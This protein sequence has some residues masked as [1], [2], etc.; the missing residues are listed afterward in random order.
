[1]KKIKLQLVFFIIASF[2]SFSVW[3]NLPYYPIEF[4]RDEAGHAENVP[5]QFTKMTEWWYYN[6]TLT[7]KTG[8]KFGYYISFNSMYHPHP[9]KMAGLFQ[10]QITD[11]DKKKVYAKQLFFLDEKTFSIST[12]DLNISFGKKLSLYKKNASYI[13]EGSVL[14]ED[15]VP[16]DFSLDLTQKPTTDVLLV[17]GK[18]LMPMWNNTN[19]YYYSYT[20]LKTKGYLKIGKEVFE[21]DPC[22]SLSW[23]DHQWGDFII[24][25]GKNQWMWTSIQLKN[26]LDIN[27]GIILDDNLKPVNGSASLVVPS[28]LTPR[29]FITDLSKLAYTAEKVQPGQ[30][31]PLV[32]HLSIPFMKLQITSEALVPGQDLNGIWE[33]VSQVTGTYKDQPITGQSYTESTVVKK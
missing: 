8:R 5:Y 9:K 16:L 10:I 7:S 4:P 21:L 19:S 33:G 1:M 31:H 17:G 23:M 24:I 26:G 14:S 27:L 22:Q 3:A 15:G 28:K 6:G 29:V 20:K 32:Y 11:I 18:G 2:L 13:V 12:Q 30:K 25:P